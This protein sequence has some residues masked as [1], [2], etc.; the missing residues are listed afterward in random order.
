M[1]FLFWHS[2]SPNSNISLHP[3][4]PQV[5]LQLVF[6]LLKLFAEGG[7]P[8]TSVQRIAAAAYADGWGQGDELA[9][10]LKQAGGRGKHRS[11]C[12]R[13]VLRVSKSLGVGNVT[14]SRT[15]S[16]C[17]AQMAAVVR[18]QCACH[19]SNTKCSCTPMAW[20]PGDCRQR[21]LQPLRG[22]G[23]CCRPGATNR[24]YHWRPGTW[25]CWACMLTESPTVPQQE[26]AMR[27]EFWLHPG[28]WC[29]LPSKPTEGADSFFWPSARHF[30]AT[31]VAR[32]GILST[33]C[34]KSGLGAWAA[35]TLELRRLA[36][37]M[38]SRGRARM[39]KCG[40][41]VLFWRELRS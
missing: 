7:L 4:L 5:M 8:A 9:E 1:Y 40:C 22:L 38:A 30:V 28:M 34:S 29:Q 35:C 26:Q 36:D 2:H 12:L 25:Q 19:M 17:P 16:R 41:K 39:R 13:D 10:R 23:P 21:H 15:T 14:P 31:V 3:C 33:L 11:N 32:V 27:R 18:W 37:T 20:V 6:E 24:R